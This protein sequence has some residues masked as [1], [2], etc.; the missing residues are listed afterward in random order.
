MKSFLWPKVFVL[1]SF[2]ILS[3]HA[4]GTTTNTWTQ[5]T[6]AE[7]NK[8]I[9]QNVSI[10]NKGEIQL[11][12][13]IEIMEG[14]KSAFVWSLALDQQNQVFVGTGDPGTIYLI[15]NGSE[16]VEFFKSPEL[17]VQSLTTDKQ[18]NLYAGTAPRG[19]I[20]KINNKGEATTFCSL[21]VP[22]IWGLAVDGDSNLFAA[23]GNEGILFK[24]SPDGIP[25]IFFDSPETNLLAIIVDQNNNTYV[26]TEPNG[27]VYKVS[28][29]GQTQVLY[30]ASEDEIHCLT[31]N[32][33]N[34]YAGTASGAQPQV[35]AASAT[36][37]P[38]QT[39][40]VTPIFRE[41]K[42]WD[43]NLP[44]ELPM[45]QPVSIQQQK[46][47]VKG[48]D[49]PPKSTSIPMVTNYIYKITPEGLAQKIFEAGQAFILGMSA[50]AQNNLYVV[51]GNKPGVY[52]IGNDETSSSLVN[53]E[54]VQVL[55]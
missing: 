2:L 24:I 39:G 16:A 33:G 28:S 44:E 25:S 51:T 5:S 6:E 38:A 47:A 3:P 22:Y 18:G 30:D 17:Y 9:A 23:T 32:S 19:I 52:K 54:E 27:L 55:C 11:S 45:A 26:G 7:F 42:A 40:I 10:L 20:Y 15:K 12:P 1:F 37:P 43:L 48:I 34:I 8:G 14:I 35:P 29:L 36:Q 53:V 46:P 41:E 13:R 49:A 4:A 31:M 21:P 50:D